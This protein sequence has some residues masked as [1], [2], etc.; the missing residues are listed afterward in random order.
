MGIVLTIMA[1]ITATLRF[2]ITVEIL[3]RREQSVPETEP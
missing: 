2:W 1:A 3:F